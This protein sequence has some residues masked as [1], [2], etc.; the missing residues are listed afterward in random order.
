[1]RNLTLKEV[2]ESKN[3]AE[4]C[5]L[6]NYSLEKIINNLGSSFAVEMLEEDDEEYTSLDMNYPYNIYNPFCLDIK[7][8]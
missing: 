4:F 6:S 2:K 7:A 3:F 1:M 5:E 8:E